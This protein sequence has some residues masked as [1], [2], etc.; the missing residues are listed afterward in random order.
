MDR[1]ISSTIIYGEKVLL[2]EMTIDDAEFIVKWRNDPAIQKWMFNQDKIS[3]EGHISWFKKRK[4]RMDYIICEAE[5]GR[6]IG[7][8]N[9]I[10]IEEKKAEAGKMLGDKNYWGGGYAKE[11]FIL[12]LNIGFNDLGFE[13]IYVKTMTHNK[14][15]IGLNSKLGF[16][17]KEIQMKEITDKLKVEVLVMTISKE[18]FKHL[19]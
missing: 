15:N 1:Q 5:N 6:P 3:V 7:T 14:S 18:N 4:D 17:E 11:A 16:K 9:F 19:Q 2:R 10:N 12:W 8:V 13:E